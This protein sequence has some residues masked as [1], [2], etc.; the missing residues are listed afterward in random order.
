MTTIDTNHLLESI[1][2]LTSK[3]DLHSLEE[4]LVK[5]LQEI[6]SA[7]EIVMLEISSEGNDQHTLKLLVDAY[8]PN[9]P[10]DKKR[11][12]PSVM[13]DDPALMTCFTTE[14]IVTTQCMTDG[15]DRFIHPIM[16]VNGITGF[17]IINCATMTDRDQ[18]ITTS[19]LKIYYNYLQLMNDTERDTLTGLLN[20]KTLENRVS[21][22]ISSQH[23][24]HRRSFDEKEH[25]C[26]AILDI[27]HFKKINDTFGHLY[28]DEVLLLFAQ[29]MTKTFRDGDLLFR[30]GGEEFVAILK[31]ADLKLGLITL[32]RFKKAVESFNFPQVGKV[33]VSIG[34]VEITSQDMPITIIGQADQA[35][36]Y[37]KKNGRNQVHAYEILIAEGKLTGSTATGDI[38]LF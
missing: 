10:K 25:Y 27:D 13:E 24:D 1:V 23:S 22:I 12:I 34:V 19:I 31:E 16:G 3:R 29:I 21:H 18:D 15:C 7:Q 28:G 2:Q 11:T 30:Y 4:S 14:K 36:Y 35:L 37:A 5:S 20:R 26:L 38:E 17:L 8:A 6:I 32:E 9:A 33:T